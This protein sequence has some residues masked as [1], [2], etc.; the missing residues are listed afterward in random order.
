M[1]ISSGGS[2][3]GLL[4]LFALLSV[5][6]DQHNWSTLPQDQVPKWQHTSP[7]AI[8]GKKRLYSTNYRTSIKPCRQHLVFLLWLLVCHI[9]LWKLLLWEA[10]HHISYLTVHTSCKCSGTR[11]PCHSTPYCPNYPALPCAMTR[12]LPLPVTAIATTPKP[13]E[14]PK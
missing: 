6:W 12:H 11:A 7:V 13:E 10:V 3:E 8:L 5:V 1:R 14:R 2:G 9:S 4:F